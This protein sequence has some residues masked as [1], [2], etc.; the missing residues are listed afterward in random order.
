MWSQ[1]D[2][3]RRDE[4]EVADRVGEGQR[5]LKNKCSVGRIWVAKRAGDSPGS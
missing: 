1:G 5:T 2:G 3:G 4:D